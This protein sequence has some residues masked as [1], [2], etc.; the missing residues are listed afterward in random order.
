M[1][2]R[3]SKSGGFSLI[4]VAIAVG[5]AAAGL[6]AVLALLPGILRQ[7]SDSQTAIVAS[8]LP[9]AVTVQLRKIAGSSLSVLGSRAADFS[10][11]TSQLRLVAMAD[12]SDVRELVGEDGRGQFFLIE[13]YRFPSGGETSY[14]PN[15]AFVALQV[16]VS[17]PYRADGLA[18]HESTAESRQSTIFNVVVNQ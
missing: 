4:E 17:W 14:D 16:R 7:A 9:D 13:I 6:V 5:V 3:G 10:S 15:A 18:A 8:A 1:I 11:T 2:A 12:G